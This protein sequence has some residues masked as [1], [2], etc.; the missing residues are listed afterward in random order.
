VFFRRPIRRPYAE[1]S[2]PSAEVFIPHRADEL[3]IS[4]PTRKY[5]GTG[6][7]PLYKVHGY[8]GFSIAPLTATANGAPKSEIQH[9]EVP[10]VKPKVKLPPG[11]FVPPEETE[12]GLSEYDVDIEEPLEEYVGSSFFGDVNNHEHFETSGHLPGY[13]GPFPPSRYGESPPNVQDTQK[14]LQGYGPP[15][16]DE[17]IG[18]DQPEPGYTEHRQPGYESRLLPPI[19]VRKN[20]YDIEKYDSGDRDESAGGNILG[21]PP[22]ELTT[23]NLPL[24]NTPTREGAGGNVLGSPPKELTTGDLPLEN[25]PTQGYQ[26]LPSVFEV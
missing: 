13:A 22:K 3:T 7:V 24:E 8:K 4:H 11:K 15:A 26:G 18:Y 2:L 1:E 16:P 19:P 17:Y 10:V 21:P 20:F 14:S 25:T 12:I 23:G 5:G 6:G 9:T